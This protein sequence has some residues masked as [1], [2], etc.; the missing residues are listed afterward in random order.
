MDPALLNEG[1][2]IETSISFVVY[3]LKAD[4]YKMVHCLRSVALL[5]SEAQEVGSLNVCIIPCH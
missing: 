4:H 3:R 1:D 2:I 5:S